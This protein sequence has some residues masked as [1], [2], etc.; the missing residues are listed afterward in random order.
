MPHVPPDIRNDTSQALVDVT[1]TL[2]LPGFDDRARGTP[3]RF[4]GCSAV[5]RRWFPMCRKK[6]LTRWATAIAFCLCVT[7][8]PSALADN[9]PACV[10]KVSAYVAE[11]DQL[12]STKIPWYLPDNIGPYDELQRKY[13][14]FGD[15]DGD[16][17]LIEATKSRF[18]QDIGYNPRSKNDIVQFSNGFVRIGFIYDGKKRKV[19]RS[20]P[21]WVR[22][23][24]FNP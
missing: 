17:I 11:L 20:G 21:V 22:D 24:F 16:P 18:L 6:F 7:A 23:S 5:L 15:C 8:A 12:L 10:A 19:E 1:C 13:F 14:P 9:T 2:G 3:R 4:F